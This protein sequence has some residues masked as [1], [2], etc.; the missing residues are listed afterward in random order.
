MK[1]PAGLSAVKIE[2]SDQRRDAADERDQRETALGRGQQIEDDDEENSY[3]ENDLRVK[4][5]Q[6]ADVFEIHGLAVQCGKTIWLIW[7]KVARN[8]SSTTAG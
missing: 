7:S 2:R 1:Q 3:R 4:E 5:T 6:A 8:I